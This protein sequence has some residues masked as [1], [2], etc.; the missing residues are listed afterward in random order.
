MYRMWGGRAP[1][2]WLIAASSFQRRGI[3]SGRRDE[4]DVGVARIAD[5]PQGEFKVLG[6]LPQGGNNDRRDRIAHA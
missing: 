4:Q 2:P 5:R 6:A 3:E 1:N